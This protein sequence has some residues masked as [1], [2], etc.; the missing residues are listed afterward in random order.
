M[1]HLLREDWVALSKSFKQSWFGRMWVIQELV[2]G[3]RS[4]EASAF[5][6]FSDLNIS[7]ERFSPLLLVAKEAYLGFVCR[8]RSYHLGCRESWGEEGDFSVE[9]GCPC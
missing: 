2:F 4:D 8:L 7:L 3:Y 9:S 1:H 5:T 6:W